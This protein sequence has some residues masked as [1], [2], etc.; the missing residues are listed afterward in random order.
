M[1]PCLEASKQNAEMISILVMRD[2]GSASDP[3]AD[4]TDSFI[5]PFT[6]PEEMKIVSLTS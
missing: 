4:I 1:A 6:R 2:I 3:D 5:T